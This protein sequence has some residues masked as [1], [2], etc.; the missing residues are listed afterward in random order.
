MFQRFANKTRRSKFRPPFHALFTNKLK[1]ISPP[2]VS[3]AGVTIISFTVTL[4]KRIAVSLLV[5]S[6][7]P[8]AVVVPIGR[9]S[10]VVMTLR[11]VAVAVARVLGARS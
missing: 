6:A 9:A 11:S 1:L 2:A 4:H 3:V 7:I 10:E 8:V 5:L